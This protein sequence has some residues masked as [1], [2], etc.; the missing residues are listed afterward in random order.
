MREEVRIIQTLLVIWRI[1]YIKSLKSVETS[2]LCAMIIFLYRRW[3]Y[4]FVTRVI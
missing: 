3:T 4:R 1:L 2:H